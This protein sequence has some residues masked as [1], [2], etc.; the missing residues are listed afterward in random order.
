MVLDMSIYEEIKTAIMG[1]EGVTDV[2][3]GYSEKTNCYCLHF[4]NND[5]KFY[6]VS[7]TKHSNHFYNSYFEDFWVIDYSYYTPKDVI[8]ILK[9]LFSLLSLYDTDNMVDEMEALADA[10][11]LDYEYAD[12]DDQWEKLASILAERYINDNHL[13]DDEYG[14]LYTV[15]EHVCINAV[16]GFWTEM[17]RQAKRKNKERKKQKRKGRAIIKRRDNL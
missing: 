7:S 15:I 16:I 14:V 13:L 3:Y 8:S 12:D 5:R 17:R 1:M 10:M 9:R 11:K 2:C 4:T 6:L